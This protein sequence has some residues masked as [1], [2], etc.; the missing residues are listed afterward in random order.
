MLGFLLEYLK[1]RDQIGAVAPSSRRLAR[2]MTTSVG[3]GTPDRVLEVGAGTGVFTRAI[4]DRLGPGGS[5]DIVELSPRFCE[6]L[7]ER[8]VEPWTV[9]HPGHDVRVIESGL[10]EADLADR[11]S[12]IVCGL[13]FN[14]FPPSAARGLLRRML[15]LLEPG[16]TLAFF[17]YVGIRPIRWVLPGG[18]GAARHGRFI[19]RLESRWGW[20]R[21]LVL[22]NIPP[23]WAV[24]LR[25]EEPAV[26]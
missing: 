23:A 2:A 21:R 15:G 1:H 19:D 5:V 16:G 25:I 17:E 18:R 9:A 20:H 24:H 14:S 22:G 26:T 3:S 4:L 8:V 12:A 7:R 10:E 13:P 6:V 11:Y